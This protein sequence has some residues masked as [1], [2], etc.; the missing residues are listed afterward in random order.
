MSKEIIPYEDD[1]QEVV[2]D[3]LEVNNMKFSMIPNATF[4]PSWS[5]KH[6]NRK[7]GLR[8]GL[9]DLL[10]CCRLG[11][12]FIEMKRRKGGT[13]SKEQRAW[14]ERLN[15]YDGVEARVC[16]GSEE[17]IQFILENN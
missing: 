6:K 10:I 3:W 8:P 17:A 2:V 11:L 4:T 9:P 5:Q 15:E 14:I 1:E 13:V 7:L 12:V 16:R